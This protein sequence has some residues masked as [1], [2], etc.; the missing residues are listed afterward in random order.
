MI[1]LIDQIIEKGFS[2]DGMGTMDSNPDREYIECTIFNGTV[3]SF[4]A[5]L[6]VV[7]VHNLFIDCLYVE[8]GVENQGQAVAF[9]NMGKSLF[10]EG[11]L[12]H[13]N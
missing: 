4:K 3:A 2:I 6:S 1:I 11:K 5:L 9:V 7:P 8:S 10:T 12:I 13:F